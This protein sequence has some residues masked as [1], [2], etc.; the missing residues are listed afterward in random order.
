MIYDDYR[1]HLET[2]G[3]LTIFSDEYHQWLTWTGR[4]VAHV[5]LRFL[6]RFPLIVFDVVSAAAFTWLVTAVVKVSQGNRPLK[7]STRGFMYLFVFG[8]LWV[9]TPAFSEVFF[10]MSGAANYELVMVIMMAF[11]LFYH[12]AVTTERSSSKWSKVLLMFILGI[13]AGWCNENTSGAVILIAAGYVGITYFVQHKK[14]QLWMLS[15]IIGNLIGLLIMVSAPGNAIR[16]TYFSRSQ[17]SLIWKVIDGMSWLFSSVQDKGAVLFIIAI[18]LVIFTIWQ[19]G[20]GINEMISSIFLLGGI[21]ALIVLVISPTGLVWSRSFFGAIF[22][23]IISISMSTI[24]LLNTRDS[25]NHLGAALLIAFVGFNSVC[26][27][28]S[29]VSDIYQNHTSYQRQLSSLLRQRDKGVK[30]AVVPELTY[31]AKTKYAYTARK[32]ISPDM[33]SPRN[34]QT[35]AYW[36]VK[37]VRIRTKK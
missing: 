11:L 2:R 22:F 37:T 23:V 26:G 25:A 13:L 31:D 6:L 15:G 7:N 14:I 20:L 3:F 18:S 9:F 29:G 21:A 1:Y 30:N 24:N 36:G 10:W 16:S 35:A 17:L 33:N 19:N 4:S 8:L 5:I 28:F 34:K 27:F 32:D 12:R